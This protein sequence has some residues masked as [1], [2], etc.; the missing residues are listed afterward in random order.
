MVSAVF[1]LNFWKKVDLKLSAGTLVLCTSEMNEY[2]A[3]AEI[4]CDYTGEKL[5]LRI[6]LDYLRETI[7]HIE[8][9]RVLVRFSEKDGMVAVLPVPESNY[10]FFI[11]QIRR[12]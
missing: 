8:T 6:N 5:E 11:M 2:F 9:E 1:S 4:P 12:D 7:E 10:H 3:E